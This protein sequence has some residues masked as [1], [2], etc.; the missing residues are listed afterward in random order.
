MTARRRALVLYPP[1]HPCPYSLRVE[2]PRAP[3]IPR[4]AR[5][6]TYKYEQ[7]T[8]ESGPKQTAE[9]CFHR[10]RQQ[11][12]PAVER[13]GPLNLRTPA[14]P[15]D[16]Q[17]GVFILLVEHRPGGKWPAPGQLRIA[18]CG[19]RIYGNASMAGGGFVVVQSAIRNP[20]SAIETGAAPHL[21]SPAFRRLACRL[22][23]RRDAR[24]QGFRQARPGGN[25]GR[26]VGGG[27][28]DFGGT[29]AKQSGKTVRRLCGSAC[30]FSG[31]VGGAAVC[32][33]P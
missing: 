6:R 25:D 23:H 15:Q 3:E 13:G 32:K 24:P 7:Y 4:A 29:S 5:A 9:R 2:P 21:D 27:G 8:T 10:V 31:Y 26:Q 30:L 18:N 22:D 11:F 19:L 16:L 14:R 28:A 20:Q 17:Q 33:P 12:F 1:S